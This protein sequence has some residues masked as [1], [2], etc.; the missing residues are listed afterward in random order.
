MKT[1][2]ITEG[3]A[4]LGHWLKE[5]L[6]GKDVGFIVG[7]KIVSLRPV[8]VISADYALHEYGVSEAEAARL[9]QR[10]DQAIARER[11]AGTVKRFTGGADALRD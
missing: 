9:A 4:N 7:S 5:A 8:E 2:T 6:A 10:L 3:R 11:K 1:L